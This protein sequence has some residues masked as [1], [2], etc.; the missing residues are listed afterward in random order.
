V[1]AIN[2]NYLQKIIAFSAVIEFCTGLLLIIDPALVV[3]L[4]L[5]AD[6]SGVAI[7]LGQ[8]FGIG[9]LALGLACWPGKLSVANHASPFRALLVYNLLVALYL[10]Y[11]NLH[12]QMAG[13]L[14]WP[15]VVLHGAVA[16]ALIWTLKKA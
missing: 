7:F 13:M 10:A 14:L 3:S 16:L 2:R 15:A 4:L 11:L 1:N 8:F 9:L 6:I 5:G 12:L